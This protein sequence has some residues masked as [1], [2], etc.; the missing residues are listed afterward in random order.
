MYC[1]S[2]KELICSICLC[3]KSKYY[4]VMPLKLA[5][6]TL[7]KENKYNREESKNI[8]SNI[9]NAEKVMFKNVE[10]FKQSYEEAFNSV[11]SFF[12]EIKKEVEVA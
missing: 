5:E 8:L 4:D 9:E 11:G 10:L 3:S 12:D 1:R 2:M 7:R 6:E